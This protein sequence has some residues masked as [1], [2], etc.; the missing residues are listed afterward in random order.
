MSQTISQSELVPSSERMPLLLERYQ[1]D[2]AQQVHDKDAAVQE[3][4]SPDD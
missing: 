1:A 4:Y 3:R 2:L